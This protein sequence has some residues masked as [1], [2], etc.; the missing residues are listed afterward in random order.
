MSFRWLAV[1]FVC[2]LVGAK[3]KESLDNTWSCGGG[4]L[5]SRLSRWSQLQSDPIHEY[6][7]TLL[8]LPFL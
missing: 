3:S 8:V 2:V 1:A 5:T 6:R 4:A 7:V